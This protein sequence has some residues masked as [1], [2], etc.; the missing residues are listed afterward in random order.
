MKP[1]TVQVYL[2]G[3]ID[4]NRVEYIAASPPD[5]RTSFSGSGLP[6][7]SRD[8]AM[9]NTPNTGTF[10]VN[11]DGIGT[12]AVYRP[13]KYYDEKFNVVPPRIE[14]TYYTNG[15]KQSSNIILDKAD[16][17]NRTLRYDTERV[18]PV[19]YQEDD[20]VQTTQE[21]IIRSKKQTI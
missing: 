17:T 13:N 7:T 21:S 15:I 2:A 11:D 16:I 14:L 5:S 1:A 4:Y 6:F 8:Q 19:Y 3:D 10:Y 20:R 9:W 18:S 12:V